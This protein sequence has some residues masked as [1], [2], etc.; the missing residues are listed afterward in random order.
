MSTDPPAVCHRQPGVPE[1]ASPLAGAVRHGRN[2]ATGGGGM[3]NLRWVSRAPKDEGRPSRRRRAGDCRAISS[4]SGYAIKPAPGQLFE[5]D[6]YFGCA[7]TTCTP[8]TSARVLEQAG[9]ELPRWQA[10]AVS[11]RHRLSDTDPR[12]RPGQQPHS[13][14]SRHELRPQGPVDRQSPAAP[15]T[16][17]ERDGSGEGDGADRRPRQHH[18]RLDAR[19]PGGSHTPAGHIRS[20]GA[21]SVSLYQPGSTRGG[22]QRLHLQHPGQA[23]LGGDRYRVR[24]AA[25]RPH[26]LAF[27]RACPTTTQLSRL[28]GGTTVD[29][30]ALLTERTAIS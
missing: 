10:A 24:L 26:A 5:V 18:P 22:R 2:G 17:A 9:H 29:R 7:P 1:L 25:V 19:Q 28:H 23:R 6:G 27:G 30:I 4:R 20:A 12:Q 13:R 14:R 11:D 3:P 16:D 21:D 15:G 8:S